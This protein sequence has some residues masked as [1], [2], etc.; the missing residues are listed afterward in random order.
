M[1]SAIITITALLIVGEGASALQSETKRLRTKDIYKTKDISTASKAISSAGRQN[2][3]GGQR[4]ESSYDPIAEEPY[5]PYL[6][7]IPRDVQ[8]STHRQETAHRE[9][10]GPMS[11]MSLSMSMPSAEDMPTQSIYEIASGNEAFSTLTAVIDTVG[12]AETLS[13]PDL[14]LTVFAPPNSAFDALPNGT[15]ARLLEPEWIHHLDD[16]LHK[17][18]LFGGKVMSTDLTDG[19]TA[20]AVNGDTLTINLNPPRVDETALILVDDGL[21]DIE[22]SNGVIHAISEVLLPTSAT[23]NIVDI[24]V[25]N[26][27]LST[28]VAAVQAA[29]LVDALSGDGPITVFAPTNAALANLPDGLL[30]ELLADPTKLTEILTYHVV[31]GNAH[32]S[33]LVDGPVETLNGETV[34]V[35]TF[36][37]VMINDA[38]VV[39]ADILA[40][41]GIIH[42]IDK[43]LIP[44]GNATETAAPV[45]APTSEPTFSPSSPPTFTVEGG[46]N[47]TAPTPS[48]QKDT[49]PNPVFSTPDDEEIG[50][51]EPTESSG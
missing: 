36:G 34:D 44:P 30:D 4:K 37:G 3:S 43:V 31:N 11:M 41:N 26:P 17:H 23:S 16:V 19:M 32:S 13:N 2:I 51:T 10:Q 22:A 27:D 48:P 29:G 1:F 35:E 6:G 7:L 40:S 49:T 20:Q 21:V 28:L 9:L 39:T 33:N 18:V 50:F 15:V 45:I 47:T 46:K 42:V 5:D 24:A 25:A 38:N 14:T 8:K 12:S